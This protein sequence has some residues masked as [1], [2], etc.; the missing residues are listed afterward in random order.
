MNGILEISSLSYGMH[1]HYLF[2]GFEKKMDSKM[3]E[4]N[5]IGKLS[6]SREIIMKNSNLIIDLSM[7]GEGVKPRT[8][9]MA[10]SNLH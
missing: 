9:R 2:F 4:T 7:K 1:A 6:G 8:N 10:M 3:R 5:G